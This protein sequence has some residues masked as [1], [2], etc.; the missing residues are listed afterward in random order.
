MED[1]RKPSA[2]EYARALIASL[3]SVDSNSRRER[4]DVY[5]EFE[6]SLLER[7]KSADAEFPEE[8]ATYH[9]RLLRLV[10]RLVE[11]DIRAGIDFLEQGYL[12]DELADG[13]SKLYAALVVQARRRTAI[14]AREVTAA[15]GEA[16]L[17]IETKEDE[18]A[19][20]HL[21]NLLSMVDRLAPRPTAEIR[22]AAQTMIVRALFIGELQNIIAEGRLAFIWM[23]VQPAA[24]LAAISLFYLITATRYILNM[25]VPTFALLGSATWIMCRQVIFR[26]SGTFHSQRPL[27]N[28]PP[29]RPLETALVQGMLYVMIY[30]CVFFV[31]LSLGRLVDLLTM[32]EHPVMVI[33]YLVGMWIF[34]FSMGLIFGSISV[35]APLF[36]RFASVIERILLMFSSVFFISEQL[37][38]AYKPFLLW[39]P[40]AHGMQ[41]LKAAYFPG[42]D[43]PDA[44]VVYFIAW[45]SSL[46]IFAL[47]FERAVRPRVNPA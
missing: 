34:A 24:L 10:V 9:H 46:L 37:P 13:D 5:A 28:L 1:W 8:I 31:L 38:E 12:P 36:L 26:V 19:A 21:A 3:A 30:S 44:S 11:Q 41:L 22:P 14:R 29:V 35:M 25:D 45:I 15:S 17:E 42:Y 27:F 18:T 33:C 7:F 23:L 32:P 40:T 16:Q 6:T 47:L 39:S 43:A 20:R 4:N 2:E